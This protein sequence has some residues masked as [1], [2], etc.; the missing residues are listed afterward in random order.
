LQINTT[1]AHQPWEKSLSTS[2][3]LPYYVAVGAILILS[4]G[5]MS[6]IL[7]GLKSLAKLLVHIAKGFLKERIAVQ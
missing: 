6:S 4:F 3:G 7:M 5:D 1:R 2:L